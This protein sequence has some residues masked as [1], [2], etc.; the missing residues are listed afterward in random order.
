M[1]RNILVVSAL[2]ITG[3]LAACAP[4]APNDPR[5]SGPTAVD[6]NRMASAPG[7]PHISLSDPSETRDAALSAERYL[8]T[9]LPTARGLRFLEISAIPYLRR[10]PEGAA[11][12]SRGLPRALARGAPAERCPAAAVSAA[13]LPSSSGA[14]ESALGQCLSLLNARGADTSCECR[15]LAL[16]NALTAPRRD[17]AFAPGV[18]AF[19]IRD[20]SSTAL[21]LIAESELASGDTETVI[22]RD[23]ADAVAVLA[24]RGDDAA[25]RFASAPDALWLGEREMFGYRR[26]RLSERIIFTADDGRSIRLLIGVEDRDAVAAR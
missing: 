17:F 4:S 24:L 23:A 19:L 26:G 20:D 2:L 1:S 13:G 3:A 15:V 8:R 7:A 14:V 25:L 21:R 5:L 16:D 12:L 9:R 22:L 11:F 6:L 18:S 10:S